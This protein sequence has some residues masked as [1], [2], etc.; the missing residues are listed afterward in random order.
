M[1][2]NAASAFDKGKRAS[3]L[4]TRS[5]RKEKKLYKKIGELSMDT[6]LLKKS[7]RRLGVEV[8]SEYDD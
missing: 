5:E 7:C 8:P 6:E 3:D 2:A 1:V 4:A